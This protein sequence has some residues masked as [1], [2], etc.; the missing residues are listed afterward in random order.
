I[1][2]EETKFIVTP[3]SLIRPLPLKYDARD[4]SKLNA[5]DAPLMLANLIGSPA[6]VIPTG[7]SQSSPKSL[8][9]IG[10]V[11][12]DYTLLSIAKAIELVMKHE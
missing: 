5:V 11:W 10:R 2:N 9:L 1:L 12:S 6:I 4:L 3:G 7:F 8:Q